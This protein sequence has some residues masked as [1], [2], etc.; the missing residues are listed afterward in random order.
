M[1][2]RILLRGGVAAALVALVMS[3]VQSSQADEWYPG[4]PDA[5]FGAWTNTSQGG[6]TYATRAKQW[7]R[8]PTGMAVSEVFFGNQDGEPGRNWV[9]GQ[10]Y[11]VSPQGAPATY[12]YL[13]SMTVRSVGFGMMPVE[14]TIQ[15]SQRREDGYPIP[16]DITMRNRLVRYPGSDRLDRSYEAAAINDSVNV[17]VLAVRIDGVDLELDGDC[18]TREPAPVSLL[19]PAYVIEDAYRTTNTIEDWYRTQ[20]PATYFH[21]SWGGQLSGT[22]TIPPFT[23]CT[24]SAGDDLS[25][26]LTLSASGPDNPISARAGWPCVLRV[27][28]AQSPMPPG[29]SSPKLGSAA[30]GETQFGG[31][32]TDGCVGVKPFAYPA[33]EDD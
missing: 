21:P 25:D 8:S 33:R 28:G 6:L 14:A 3:G 18:R 10:A 15:V 23:G 32:V 11:F 7:F 29:V 19:S 9:R 27:N 16:F 22:I 13:E 4:L 17:R 1:R 2:T 26:L 5:T 12:G 20:D 24:T 31:R 30:G